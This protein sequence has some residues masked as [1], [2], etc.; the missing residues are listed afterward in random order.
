MT[1]HAKI[2]MSHFDYKGDEFIPCEICNSR[3]NDIHHVQGRG[4]GMDVISNLMAL[5]RGCH[6][7]IHNKSEYTK[8]QVQEIHNN[9]LANNKL[10]LF[11]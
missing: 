11:R 3:S 9:F 4:K 10:Y 2:Y 6:N 7:K 5:C 8:S 1:K